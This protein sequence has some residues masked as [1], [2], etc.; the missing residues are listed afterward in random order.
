M[1]GIV[2][3][4]DPS[5]DRSRLESSLRLLRH[6]GPDD[7]GVFLDLDRHVGL[8]HA[9]LSIIDLKTGAQP[10]YSHDAR[11]VLVCHGE[12]YDFERQRIELESEEA[13]FAT[14]TRS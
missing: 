6:R 7:H 12:I 4:V 3:V 8:G 5:L 14:Q 9:R 13:R 1:C 10:L 2:G 11:L